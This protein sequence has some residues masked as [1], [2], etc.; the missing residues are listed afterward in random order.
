MLRKRR[1]WTFSSVLLTGTL[2]A[3]F[4]GSAPLLAQNIVIRAVDGK[5]G[6]PLANEH[7]LLFLYEN[8]KDRTQIP[9]NSL[10]TDANGTAVV[11][12]PRGHYLQVWVNAKTLC[13]ANP[14]LVALSI[15]DIR[16]HGG[17]LENNCSRNIR[18]EAKPNEVVVYARQSTL[19]EKMAW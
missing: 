19:R 14:N 17:M 13:V 11:N 3:L 2:S 18:V 12:I 8:W 16:A 6:K 9:I 10:T 4:A 5:S 1:Q 15:E 7:L